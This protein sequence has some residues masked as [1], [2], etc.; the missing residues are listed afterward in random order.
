MA[1][2]LRALTPSLAR[3]GQAAVHTVAR[4]QQGLMVE[5]WK[6]LRS[7][8]MEK[9]LKRPRRMSRTLTFERVMLLLNGDSTEAQGPRGSG[10][11]T[12]DG[13]SWTEPSAES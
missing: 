7:G 13:D 3:G 10:Q 2:R 6:G 8:P 4:G 9:L 11:R 5:P 1:Q 12:L